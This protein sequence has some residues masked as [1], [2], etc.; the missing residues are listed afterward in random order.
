MAYVTAFVVLLLVLDASHDHHGVLETSYD[1]AFI[2]FSRR[3]AF[4]VFSRREAFVVFSR[5]LAVLYFS[6]LG[7]GIRLTML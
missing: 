4:V 7:V 5:S 2:I 6:S 1:D 3:E